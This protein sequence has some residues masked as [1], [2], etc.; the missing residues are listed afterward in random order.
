MMPHKALYKVSASTK[1]DY[2]FEPKP[3]QGK[4]SLTL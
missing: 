4:A 2:R 1:L 3:L